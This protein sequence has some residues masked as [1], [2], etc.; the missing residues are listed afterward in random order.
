MT[1]LELIEI[2]SAMLE[3]GK[4]SEHENLL[5]TLE[6]DLETYRLKDVIAGRFGIEL[7]ASQEH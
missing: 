4:L 7:V 3:D 1:A 6:D 2:L 5:V